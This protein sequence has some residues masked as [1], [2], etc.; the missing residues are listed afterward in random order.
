MYQGVTFDS[1]EFVYKDSAGDVIDISS[2]DGKMLMDNTANTDTLELLSTDVSGSRLIITGASGKVAP[3]IV[4]ADTEGL[5]PG[6]Y[7]YEIIIYNGEDPT[8]LIAKGIIT[9]I[10][11]RVRNS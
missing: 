1:L 9:L 11:T 5:T 10:Q 7:D 2:Y 8:V 4:S 3:Y 6:T